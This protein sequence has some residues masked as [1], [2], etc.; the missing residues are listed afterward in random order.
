MLS[1]IA[2]RLATIHSAHRTAIRFHRASRWLSEVEQLDPVRHADQIL[3]HQWIA[4]VDTTFVFRTDDEDRRLSS[5]SVGFSRLPICHQ[6][7][8]AES[9][10]L[11]CF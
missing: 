7:E 10:H 11:K 9:A 1:W 3:L 6:L 2:E 4:K 8:L 5:E